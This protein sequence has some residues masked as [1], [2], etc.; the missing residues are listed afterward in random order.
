MAMASKQSS[1]HKPVRRS[2]RFQPA[3]LQ[4]Y[5]SCSDDQLVNEHVCAALADEGIRTERGVFG[6]RMN[7]SLVNDGPVTIVIDL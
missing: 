1:E 3:D 6:A 5:E 2:A 7:V 4:R